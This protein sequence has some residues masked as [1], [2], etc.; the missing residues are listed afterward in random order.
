MLLKLRDFLFLAADTDFV[1]HPD[2][3]QVGMFDLS[4]SLDLVHSGQQAA[5]DMIPAIK[6][7]LKENGIALSP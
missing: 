6:Q 5:Y 7:A 4:H 2:V 3:G 1:I